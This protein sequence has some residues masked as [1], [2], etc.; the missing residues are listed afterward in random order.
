MNYRWLRPDT[1][2]AVVLPLSNGDPGG[3]PTRAHSFLPFVM[4]AAT[5]SDSLARTSFLSL[6]VGGF[7]FA[8]PYV[9][10]QC[11]IGLGVQAVVV[12]AWGLAAVAAVASWITG[13]LA[14]RRRRVVL[15][16]I[17]P[18]WLAVL[19]VVVQTFVGW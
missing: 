19:F 4:P 12:F 14:L 5:S 8:V 18:M 2:S 6:L 10:A 1:A 16:W 7:L 15:L 11:G 3:L 9:A 17:V 13:T